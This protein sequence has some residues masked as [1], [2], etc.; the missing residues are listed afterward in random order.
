PAAAYPQFASAGAGQFAGTVNPYGPYTGSY[1]AAAV[2]TD[3]GYKRLTRTVDLSGVA[4]AS[5]PA[6]RT[7]LLWDTEPGY[8]NAIVEI[9]TVGSDDWTT[10]PEAGGA[11]ST[12]VPAECGAG[13]YVGEHPW[14]AHYLTLGSGDCAATGT[15][16]SWNALTGASSGWQQLDFDLSAYAGKNVEVSIAYVTDPG[17][18]GHGVLADDASLV[19]GGTATETE[20]FETSLGA[21]RAAGPPPGSPAVLKDWARTGALFRTYGAVTTDDTVLLGF[22]LEHVASPADRKALIGKALAS[23]ES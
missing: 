17:S 16:G 9:H 10:L 15:T 1:M 11:T 21:W 19:V 13:F 6:L 3:D 23:L 20:G 22:G 12:A 7:R 5:K 14:L 8:D 18:G 4:A 2:H